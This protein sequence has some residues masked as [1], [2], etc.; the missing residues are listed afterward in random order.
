MGVPSMSEAV[1]C[2]SE[3]INGIIANPGCMSFKIG[4]CRNPPARLA[5]VPWAHTNSG[6]H[7]MHV[8]FV[9]NSVL[10]S[11][12]VEIALI[13]K[14]IGG[15]KCDNVKRGGDT[16]TPGHPHF[17]YVCVKSSNQLWRSNARPTGTGKRGRPSRFHEIGQLQRD[18][19]PSGKTH[20]HTTHKHTCHCGFEMQGLAF[21]L[22]MVGCALIPTH[23]ALKKKQGFEMY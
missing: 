5:L 16:P 19:Y 8:V 12:E 20:T 15:P 18:I 17:A 21:F 9:G 23:S 13:D 22:V 1:E 7:R 2:A 14:Y 4:I 11:K 10:E 6:Y 3:L